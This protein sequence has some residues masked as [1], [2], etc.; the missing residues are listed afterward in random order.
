MP[1]CTLG[2]LSSL[3]AILKRLAAPPSPRLPVSRL[4]RPLLAVPW[5]E[6]RRLSGAARPGGGAGDAAGDARAARDQGVDPAAARRASRLA[7]QL[8]R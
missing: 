4:M 2:E 7:F 3:E 6:Y 8:L 1:R 5:D